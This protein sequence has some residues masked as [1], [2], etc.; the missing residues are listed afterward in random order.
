MLSVFFPPIKGGERERE[1][2]RLNTDEKN[3]V[4]FES[5]THRNGFHDRSLD[6]TDRVRFSPR[7]YSALNR[8]PHN[9]EK[10]FPDKIYIKEELNVNKID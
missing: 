5:R 7:P 1:W 9:L 2:D 6:Y 4:T 10:S 8:T 3:A